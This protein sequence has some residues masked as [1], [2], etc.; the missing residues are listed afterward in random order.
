MA[1]AQS[2]GQ[3]DVGMIESGGLSD[4]LNKEFKPKTS[5]AK[6][7]I[8]TAVRTLA[9]Q[10]LATTAT[11]SDD[12]IKTIE[13]LIAAIDQKLSEQINLILH[14]AD[15]QQLESAWRGLSHLVSNTETDETLKIRV[16]NISKKDLSKTLGKF[17]G[18]AWDQSPVFKAVYEQE[19][20]TPGGQPYGCLVGDYYFDHTPP[21]VELL[22]QIAQIASAAHAPF[23]SAT[24]PSVMNME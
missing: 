17:K 11:V 10:A 14:H 2:Q 7:A 1:E 19:F 13:S 12:A 20:G 24:N 18:T 9:E 3:L 4:L 21:D 15:F 5:G 16:L 8:E 22:G 6:Q 23:I